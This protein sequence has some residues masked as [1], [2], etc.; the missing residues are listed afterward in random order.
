[1]NYAPSTHGTH[2]IARQWHLP[3]E[4]L[5]NQS[6]PGHLDG[7]SRPRRARRHTE[8]KRPQMPATASRRRPRVQFVAITTVKP[9]VLANPPP[10]YALHLEDE[11]AQTHRALADGVF[12]Q[13]WLKNDLSGVVVTLEAGSSAAAAALLDEFSLVKAGYADVQIVA[14]DAFPRPFR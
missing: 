14:I 9:S 2:P 12:H 6:S 7:A 3:I 8:L 11:A 4:M 10:D 5:V 1:M 13:A